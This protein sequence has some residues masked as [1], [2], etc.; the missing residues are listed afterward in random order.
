MQR[1]DQAGKL[2]PSSRSHPDAQRLLGKV[3]MQ[4]GQQKGVAHY[5]TVGKELIQKANNQPELKVDPVGGK[6]KT[7]AKRAISPRPKPIE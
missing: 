6:A 1:I 4:T 2:K 7:K 3:L 5:E